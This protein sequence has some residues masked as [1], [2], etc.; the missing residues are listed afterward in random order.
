MK[1][2]PKY[3]LNDILESLNTMTCCPRCKENSKAHSFE[4]L[5]TL[6]DG[7]TN[8]FYTNPALATE[9]DDSPEAY[10]YYMAHFQDTEPHPWIWIFDCKGMKTKDLTQ[11]RLAKKLMD[12]IQTKYKDSLRGIFI[13]NPVWCITSLFTVIKPFLHKE[14]KSKVHICS[15]GLID[16]INKLETAGVHSTTLQKLTVRLTS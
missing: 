2:S 4:K 6:R 13:I 11:S 8:V 9:P 14:A 5:G 1:G 7:V 15:L 10:Q 3:R 16:T 12:G